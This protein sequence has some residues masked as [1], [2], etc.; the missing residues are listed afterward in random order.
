MDWQTWHDDYDRPDSRLAQRL[1]VV[2]DQIRRALD[3]APPGPLKAISL[4]SGQGRD[5]LPLPKEHPRRDDVRGRLVEL[6][7][8]SASVRNCAPR[9]G[10]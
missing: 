6:I 9:A 7:P 1:R 5:L 8:A 4:C 3:A 10:R 2:Q